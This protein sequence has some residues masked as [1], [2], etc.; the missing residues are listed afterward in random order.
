MRF[1]KLDLGAER[2]LS[3][4]DSEPDG[5]LGCSSD[6]MSRSFRSWWR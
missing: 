6:T 5:V 3:L 2:D 4:F 1:E